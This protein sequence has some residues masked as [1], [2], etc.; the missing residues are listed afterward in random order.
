[1]GAGE[2]V[3]VGIGVA[4]NVGVAVGTDVTELVAVG[5]AA[6]TAGEQEETVST[7]K[8]ITVNIFFIFTSV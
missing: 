4:V 2:G 5:S 8:A 7:S 3:A 6:L 1:V